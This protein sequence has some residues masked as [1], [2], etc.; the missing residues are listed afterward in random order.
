MIK[1]R[2]SHRKLASG[3]V[4]Y[5]PGIG[6]YLLQK[7]NTGGTENAR[8]CYSVWLRHLVMANKSRLNSYPKTVAELGPGDSLGIGLSALISGCDQYFA[9]DIVDFANIERNMRIFEELVELFENRKPIP[10]DREFPNVK[11]YLET[12]NFPED[13]LDNERLG[14]ALEKSRLEAI[15]SALKNMNRKD[16][17]IQYK[18][19]WYDAKVLQDESVDMIYSQAVLE[20]IDDLRGAY[21]VMK[22]WLK[23]DGYMAHQVDFKCHGTAEEWNGHW[24]YS[25]FMWKLIKGK[26]PYLLNREPYSTHARILNEEGFKVLLN[27]MYQSE[28]NLKR[29]QL[30]PKFKTTSDTDLCTSGAYM[31]AVKG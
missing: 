9:F 2:K 18:V 19:P 29:S 21:K 23:P 20:H 22:K 11:P 15:K 25:D 5:I 30:A 26:R 1:I 28:S 6:K 13:I 10:D 31:Q 16:S 8:Y 12:Y 17:K 14:D 7:R 3:I 27:I 4:S 24:A